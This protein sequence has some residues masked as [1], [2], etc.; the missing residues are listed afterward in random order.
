MKTELS[1][2]PRHAPHRR[3]NFRNMRWA[4]GDTICGGVT[5]H[6]VPKQYE[7]LFQ[8]EV[9]TMPDVSAEAVS[10]IAV[11]LALRGR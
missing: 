3:F 2:E 4:Q 1:I 7:F 6:I 10:G 11:R 5:P 8:V 9:R